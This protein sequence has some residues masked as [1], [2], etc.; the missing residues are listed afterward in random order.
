MKA[1]QMLAAI[2]CTTKEAARMQKLTLRNALCAHTSSVQIDTLNYLTPYVL[3]L[4]L[5]C[6]LC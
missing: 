6:T 5:Y 1:L 3:T 4:V 2:Y